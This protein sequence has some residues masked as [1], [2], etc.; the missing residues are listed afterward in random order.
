MKATLKN[1]FVL[2]QLEERMGEGLFGDRYE[3]HPALTSFDLRPGERYHTERLVRLGF[4]RKTRSNAPGY[5]SQPVTLY[6]RDETCQENPFPW[7]GMANRRMQ[8]KLVL[9]EAVDLS[10]CTRSGG[11]DYLLGRVDVDDLARTASDHEVLKLAERDT[12]FAEG[13]DYCNAATEAWIWSIG[14]HRETGQVWASHQAN[15]YR[16]PAFVCIWLR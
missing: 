9:G 14:V 13:K 8:K 11:G 4:L 16:N 7:K 2:T 3:G 1:L 15:K 10:G 6:W 5:G 12:V